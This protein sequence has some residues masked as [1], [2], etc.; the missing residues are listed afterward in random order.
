MAPPGPH[1]RSRPCVMEP[2]NRNV[3]PGPSDNHGWYFWNRGHQGPPSDQLCEAVMSKLTVRCKELRPLRRD[4]PVGLAIISIVEPK[5]EIPDVAIH[6]K[7]DSR[8]VQLPAKPQTKDGTLAMTRSPA[9]CNTSRSWS[10]PTAPC[11]RPFR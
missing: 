4:T 10:S 7:G 1:T 6:Q 11:A 2:A 5:L 3:A 9:R 8:W